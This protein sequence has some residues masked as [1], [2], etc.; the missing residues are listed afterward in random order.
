MRKTYQIRLLIFQNCFD[1]VVALGSYDLFWS[2]AA[3]MLTQCD[4]GSDDFYMNDLSSISRKKLCFSQLNSVSDVKWSKVPQGVQVK[5]SKVFS[6][7][8]VSSHSKIGH[9]PAL[10]NWRKCRQKAKEQ[11]VCFAQMWVKNRSQNGQISRLLFF[12]VVKILSFFSQ[13]TIDGKVA[14]KIV[15]NLVLIL[16]N[17]YGMRRELHNRFVFLLRESNYIFVMNWLNGTN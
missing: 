7:L 3:L 16:L 14:R 5:V 12:I 2:F 17:L 1:H 10:E 11:P 4:A 8:L 6:A 13:S 9:C 15:T